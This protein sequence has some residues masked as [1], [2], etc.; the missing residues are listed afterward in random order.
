[1]KTTTLLAAVIP[2]SASRGK[3]NSAK[4]IEF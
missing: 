2:I 1:M 3:S 4:R